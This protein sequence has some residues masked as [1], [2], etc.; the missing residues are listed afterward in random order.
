MFRPRRK[1]YRKLFDIVLRNCCVVLVCVLQQMYYSA[2][3]VQEP[4]ENGALCDNCEE[5]KPVNY[6][7]EVLHLSY[8]MVHGFVSDN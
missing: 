7:C 4:Q 3:R 1:F 6:Y 2:E 8:D 5:L